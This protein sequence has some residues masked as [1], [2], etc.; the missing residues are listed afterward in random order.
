[1][2]T[3]L[4]KL[5]IKTEDRQR[6]LE[7]LGI[8]RQAWNLVSGFAFKMKQLGLSKLHKKSYRK[9]RKTLDIPSQI[10]IK[11]EQDCLAAYR[12]ARSNRHKTTV[13]FVKKRLSMRLDKR[14]YRFM[15][16]GISLTAVGGKRIFASFIKYPRLEKFL[17]YA[18]HD[19]MIFE[20]QGDIFL[21]I[22]FDTPEPMFMQGKSVGVDLGIKRAAFT[23]EGV[24][25]SR[26]SF[27]RQLRQLAFLKAELQR[28]NTRS[29]KRHLKRLSRKHK[30]ISVDFNHRIANT[31][32]RTPATTIVVE[33]LA[34]IKN[35]N[36]GTF[37]N[38]KLGHWAVGDL[39]R[40][41]QYKAL[42]LGK[43]VIMVNPAF[44]SQRDWRG[45]ADGKRCGCR[46]IASDGVVFDADW[47]A[48]MNIAGRFNIPISYHEVLD[49]QAR[50][51][52]PNVVCGIRGHTTS[53][54]ALALGG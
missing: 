19:P 28:R 16:D 41:L 40:I 6:L 49:G 22:T 46:Y 33:N 50:V 10:V 34:G 11:A 24:A 18:S 4:V 23:T 1:M 39:I 3:L 29:A 25:V 45:I 2:K 5:A 43:R 15:N 26:K 20:R 7:T 48:A 42:A 52:E 9:I 35:K 51:N 36:R 27:N 44:T 13:P 53:P 37:L 32:L 17:G 8:H 47:N 38:R 14:I 31:I 54:Y 21:A 30:R 12:S